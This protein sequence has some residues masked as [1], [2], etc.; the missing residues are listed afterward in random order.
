MIPYKH[1]YIFSNRCFQIMNFLIVKIISLSRDNQTLS[2]I[3][4]NKWSLA[5]EKAKSCYTHS[6]AQVCVQWSNDYEKLAC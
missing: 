3:C 6:M 1:R 2:I 5:G 4:Y